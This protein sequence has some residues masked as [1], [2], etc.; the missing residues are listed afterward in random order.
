MTSILWIIGGV[1]LAKTL[2][3][4]MNARAGRNG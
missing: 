1:L 2:S 3:H 4:A